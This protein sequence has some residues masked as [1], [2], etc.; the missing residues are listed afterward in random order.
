MQAMQTGA[1]PSAMQT[2]AMKSAVKT[3]MDM[4]AKMLIVLTESGNTA[5]LVAKYRPEQPILVLTPNRHVAR[6]SCGLLRGCTAHVVGSMIGT[7]GILLRAAEMGKEYG[8]VKTGDAIVAIHGM[9]EARSGATNM[10]KVL[11][12]P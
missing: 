10:L 4:N 1:M 12:V 6:Q 9:L 11:T 5:R 7:D 3:A 2:A 8:Y